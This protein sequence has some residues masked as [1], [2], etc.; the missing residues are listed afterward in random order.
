MNI[1]NIKYLKQLLNNSTSLE[2][3]IFLVSKIKKYLTCC[4]LIKYNGENIIC[5]C[6]KFNI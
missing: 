1:K 4:S 6:K 2:L 3:N 5:K